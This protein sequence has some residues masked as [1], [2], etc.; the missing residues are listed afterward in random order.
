[1]NRRKEIAKFAC[2][3]TAWEAIVHLS[4]ACCHSLPVKL[5]GITLT[6]RLNT[7]QI[8]VPALTSSLLAY[9]A[10]VRE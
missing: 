4:F 1:M 2:G 7:T 6:K 5:C 3:V 10:W 8:I 9:Y